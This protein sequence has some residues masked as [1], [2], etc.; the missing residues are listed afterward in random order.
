MPKQVFIESRN[1]TLEFPDDATQE[2]IYDFIAAEFPRTGEDVAYDM[3]KMGS[4]ADVRDFIAAIPDEDYVKLNNY[5]ADK[6]LSWGELAGISGEAIGTIV[7]DVV[8]GVKSAVTEAGEGVLESAARGVGAGTVDLVNLAQKLVKPSDR[9]PELSEFVG[10]PITRLVDAPQQPGAG[11]MAFALPSEEE[12]LANESDYRDLINRERLKELESLD[13]AEA[14]ENLIKGAPVEEV[15]RGA[16]YLDALT[17]GGLAKNIAKSGVKTIFKKTAQAPISTAAGTTPKVIPG[18]AATATIES[19]ESVI[20]AAMRQNAEAFAAKV[21]E[22]AKKAGLTGVQLGAGTVKGAADL[23]KAVIDTAGKFGLSD[24][25]VRGAIGAAVGYNEGGT[26]GAITGAVVGSVVPKVARAGLAGVSR[27][28]DFIGAAAKVAKTGPSRTGIF[29]KM[30]QATNIS[31]EARKLAEKV[32]FTQPFVQYASESVRQ[33]SQRALIG[34][35]IGAAIGYATDGEEGAAAGFGAGIGISAIGGGFDAS[36]DAVREIAGRSTARSQR[37]AIGDIKSF[38]NDITDDKARADY[39]E[40]MDQA[41]KLAGP[42]RAADMLDAL[43]LAESMGANVQVVPPSQRKNVFNSFSYDGTNG[44]TIT[45][46]P[47]RMTQGTVSHEVFHQLFNVGVKAELQKA[48]RE[49]YLPTRD[50]DGNIIKPGLYDDA[51]FAK[52]AA[53]LAERYKNNPKGYKNALEVQSVLENPAGYSEAAL[54]NARSFVIDE[55]TAEYAEAFMGRSRPGVFNPDRLPLWHRKLLQQI[56]D[57]LLNTIND[58]LYANRNIKDPTVAFTDEQGK[59]VRVPQLDNVLKRAFANKMGREKGQVAGKTEKVQQVVIPNKPRELLIFANATFGATRDVLGTDENGNPRILT[60]QEQK[61]VTAADFDEAKA[62][63]QTLT[64]DERQT[65]KVTNK[66][67]E[68]VDVNQPGARIQITSQTPE[69]VFEKF[70]AVAKS[71]G[72]GNQQLANMR[73]LFASMIANEGPTFNTVNNPVYQFDK[74]TGTMKAKVRPPTRQ[75]IYPTAITVNSAGG[76][77][78]EYIDISRVKANAQ[79]I[80]QNPKYKGVW[81]DLDSFMNDFGRSMRNLSTENPIPSAELLGNGNAKIGAIKRDLIAESMNVTLPKRLAE[82]GYVNEPVID[83]LTLFTSQGKERRVGGSAFRDF[84]IERLTEVSPTTERLKMVK[85]NAYENIVR[86]FQP[87]AF[88]RETLPNGEAMTNPDGYRIL[89]K[90]GSSLF[91]VYDDKGELIGVAKN[92]LGA[93]RM[94]QRKFIDGWHGSPH[95]FMRFM[96]QKIGTG[97]GAQAYGYGLY[98]AEDK[99]VARGYQE[100]LAGTR[101]RLADGSFADEKASTPGARKIL[102]EARA[103]WNSIGDLSKFRQN[104]LSTQL[105]AR[106]W[107]KQGYSTERNLQYVADVDEVLRLISESTPESTGS[108]YR[109]QLNVLPEQL[110]DWDKPLSEQSE[111]VRDAFR[112]WLGNDTEAFDAIQT[113]TGGEWYGQ[114]ENQ[115]RAKFK[116]EMLASMGIPGIRYLDGGSRFTG[117]G[118]H[119]YV[120]FDDGLIRILDR[121]GKPVG[122]RLFRDVAE[123]GYNVRFQP[124][125]EDAV[126]RKIMAKYD[127]WK[128]TDVL[129]PQPGQ[130]NP[131]PYSPIVKDLLIRK[132][133]GEDIPDYVIARAIDEHFQSKKIDPN[134]LNLPSQEKVLETIN[135]RQRTTHEETIQMGPPEPGTPIT[136][137]QDVPSFKMKGIGVTTTEFKKG[138]KSGTLYLPSVR[139]TDPVFSTTE[140]KEQFARAI[141][142]QEKDKGPAIKIDGKWSGDQSI[143]ADLENWTQVGF[144]PDRHSYYY[145]KGTNKQVFSGDE[146]FQ[147]GNTV[148]VKNPNFEPPAD[149]QP[150]EFRFQPSS[151][152]S[153]D[154]NTIANEVGGGEV[155]G[156]AKK[157]GAF[158]RQM[159]DKGITL[160]DVVKSYG[161]TVS[162]INRKQIPAQSIK[163]AWPDAPF[164]DGEDVRPEDAFA[165]LLGTKEGQE[166]LNSAERGE[167]NEPAADAMMQ[168]FRP[169]GLH[170]TLKKYLKN[171]AEEFFPKAQSIIDA[172]NNMPTEQFADFIPK[173]IKG[174]KHGKVGFFAGHLGRGDLPTFDSR[175]GNLVYGERVKVTKKVLMDQRDRLT[176]LGITVPD[177]YKDFAQTLLHHEVWD[178][179]NQTDTE[180]AP[181]KQ[182]MLLFQPDTASPSILNGSNGTRIIKSPSGK[183][184]VYSVTGTLLGIRDTEQAAKKLA[185]K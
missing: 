46:N 58:K 16:S 169:F 91:R 183:F 35:P 88:T 81:T 27:T 53:E 140:K 73:Q 177:E 92:E 56:D 72:M 24:A 70:L 122:K 176:Q 33:A 124:E 74:R 79:K 128:S 117:E 7:G 134:N 62:L 180:H 132:D 102:Q 143:P 125:A 2:E 60:P 63:F 182:A 64:N 57:R 151:L 118:T 34:A 22:G 10:K 31:P 123:E 136:A 149:F 164:K 98:I 76:F 90:T 9:I 12:G 39:A 133:S 168:K 25:G 109:V 19:G 86:R 51:E 145:E 4:V 113:Q 181:I 42:E 5:R 184:R 185:T 165:T 163:K 159:R 45:I 28:A 29:E 105:Q 6:K 66:V 146:A 175:M 30:A 135:S 103:T 107:A 171:A 162:S 20:P 69:S 99:G 1:Q 55:M 142:K 131:R 120:I 154:I 111:K 17:L 49:V 14:S 129:A 147:I 48:L 32:L 108:L 156:G 40:V 44:G 18:A 138:G 115:S 130:V 75:E 26:Q 59:P 85:E 148:F 137:R 104:L 172:V 144:N 38:V 15:A 157:F 41:I 106:A 8:K 121:N 101:L 112:K 173:N 3:S 153:R 126:Y 96:T 166:Y 116:S 152:T 89:K 97:E 150:S 52:K 179:L 21:G 161:I 80:L 84:R 82:K 94:A 170:N 127:G 65:V 78:V 160:R 54:D 11:F 110:L 37:N 83:P 77:N 114:W 13:L 68:P 141:A 139:Y 95:N 71:R 43:R 167:F 155:K 36:I 93:M 23:G 47:D 61:A 158:M 50:A 100:T 178:R 119:N 174:V 67:G 87:D